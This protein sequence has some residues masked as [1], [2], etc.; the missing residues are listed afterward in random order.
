VESAPVQPLSRVSRS[1]GC[2]H[3]LLDW[4]A[5][6]RRLHGGRTRLAPPSPPC[7]VTVQRD[8]PRYGSPDVD[9]HH[10]LWSGNRRLGSASIPHSG[11]SAMLGSRV[12]QATLGT[13]SV[14]REVAARSR[15]ILSHVRRWRLDTASRTIARHGSSTGA[16]GPRPP[17]DRQGA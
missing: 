11:S 2:V 9:R 1:D 13:T 17:I 6:V 10:S 5:S 3:G 12:Q 15:Q 14:A 4:V 8:A 16:A 7:I